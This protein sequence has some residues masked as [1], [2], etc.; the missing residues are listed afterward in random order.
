MVYR[1]DEPCIIVIDMH[2]AHCFKKFAGSQLDKLNGLLFA[3]SL[4][5]WSTNKVHRNQMRD[6][7]ACF[8]VQIRSELS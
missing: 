3:V 5:P 1:P 4:R 2:T 7:K 6:E 8:V